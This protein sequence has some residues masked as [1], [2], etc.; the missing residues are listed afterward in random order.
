MIRIRDP[1]LQLLVLRYRFSGTVRWLT[2]F[3]FAIRRIFALA[4]AQIR[5]R[6]VQQRPFGGG[7]AHQTVNNSPFPLTRLELG[8]S[9]RP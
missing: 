9:V 6:T 5:P 7:R 8:L 4:M 1:F 2:R 3:P